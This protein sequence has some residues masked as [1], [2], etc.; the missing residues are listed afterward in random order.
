MK[1]SAAALFIIASRERKDWEKYT[2][3]NKY[4]GKGRK[5]NNYLL[6]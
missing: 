5:N 6:E 3:I 2:A 4:S 1:L